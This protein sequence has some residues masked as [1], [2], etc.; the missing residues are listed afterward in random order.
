MMIAAFG[1]MTGYNGS[2][3][4]S[5]PGDK[6]GGVSFVGMRVCCACLGSCLIPISF[7][8][9]WLLTKRLNAAVFSSIIVLC[10]TGVLTLSQY[11]L[12]DTPLLFFIMAAAFCLLM[13]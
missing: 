12:L 10:D 11:I 3:A 4:F 1:H 2:F 9:T 7:G 8:S 13:F 5:K 6:Y